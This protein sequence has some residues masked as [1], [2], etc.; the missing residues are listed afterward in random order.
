V[1][2]VGTAVGGLFDRSAD[3]YDRINTAITFG[4]DR[5]WRRWAARSA[6]RW[7]GPRVLDACSGTGL[8][9]LEAARLGARVTLADV[10]PGMLARARERATARRLDVS[11]CLVDLADPQ[12]AAGLLDFDAITLAFGLRYFDDPAAVMRR[13]AA[14]LRPDGELVLLEAVLPDGGLVARG[15]S[16]YFFHVA[17][18]L[19]V[20]LG[21]RRELY[22]RLTASVRSLGTAA[23]V[24]DVLA[25]AG[26]DV[27]RRRR[28]V[29]GLVIGVVARR[30]RGTVAG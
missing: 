16:F 28:F 8:V 14:A 3:R 2:G 17:P 15:A 10:S 27:V 26:F 12:A 6:V 30:T 7:P 4:Q 24:A 13:L 1:A 25:A 20:L 19:A 9:G 22:D 18:R 5:R 11:T 21:G 23:D 29:G